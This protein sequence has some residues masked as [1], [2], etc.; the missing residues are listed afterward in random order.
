[1]LSLSFFFYSTFPAGLST[2]TEHWV[3]QLQAEVVPNITEEDLRLGGPRWPTTTADKYNYTF[4]CNLVVF[5]GTLLLRL[6]LFSPVQS[7][8]I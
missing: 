6:S 2:V 8:I 1:M 7:G 4:I 5:I 3:L